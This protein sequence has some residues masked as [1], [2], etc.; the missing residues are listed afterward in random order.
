MRESTVLVKEEPLLRERFPVTLKLF[1]CSTV[2]TPLSIGLAS[3]VL[4]DCV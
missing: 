4:S 2:G 3:N 1:D